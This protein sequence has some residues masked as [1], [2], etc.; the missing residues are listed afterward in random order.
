MKFILFTNK[1]F[2]RGTFL[3]ILGLV[4]GSLGWYLKSG[5]DM[6]FKWALIG[7]VILFGIGF[8]TVF[9]SLIRKVEHQSI[10]ED[11]ADKQRSKEKETV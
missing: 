8:L 1:Y 11:R 9:Y 10:M 7:G 6:L 5:T 2:L 4:L 3:I